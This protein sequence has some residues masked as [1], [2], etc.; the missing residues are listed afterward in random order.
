MKR[1][2][3]I[4]ALMTMG[5]QASPETETE[6]DTETGGENDIAA[7]TEIVEQA[8]TP[9]ICDGTVPPFQSWIA[10]DL[11]PQSTQG[12]VVVLLRASSSVWHV[13]GAD[14]TIGQ[15]IW[16]RA[17]KPS[18]IGAFLTLVGNSARAYGGVRGPVNPMCPPECGLPLLG[19]YLLA[20]AD[21]IR[22][23]HLEAQ[24]A[25]EACFP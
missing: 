24:L 10:G 12:T 21:R 19:P 23:V 9:P 16:A 25:A 5:C 2:A 6:T 20:A 7:D 17:I 3:V 11:F 1:W 15:V 14:P 22:S 4:I 8:L 13:F 18:S